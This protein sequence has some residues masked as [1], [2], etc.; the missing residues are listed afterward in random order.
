VSGATL[1]LG[2]SPRKLETKM[3]QAIPGLAQPTGY[4]SNYRGDGH[5]GYDGGHRAMQAVEFDWDGQGVTNVTL[6]SMAHFGAS[7]RD[8]SIQYFDIR[9]LDTRSIDDSETATAGSAV[10]G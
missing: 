7:H 9:A 4:T 3:M 8:V 5:A 6:P 2:V 1:L 10:S